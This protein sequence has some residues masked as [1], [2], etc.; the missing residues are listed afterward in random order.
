MK[1]LAAPKFT[2]CGVWTLSSESGSVIF[3]SVKAKTSVILSLMFLMS[4][5]NTGGPLFGNTMV[6]LN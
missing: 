2:D 3:G 4:L 1:E 6:R 5:V